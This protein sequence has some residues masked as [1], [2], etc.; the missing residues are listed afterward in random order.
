MLAE[1]VEPAMVEI[2]QQEGEVVKR[3]D[4][5]EALVEFD[6]VEQRRL[7]V[8]E[9]DIA[10]VQIAVAAAD[11]ALARAAVERRAKPRERHLACSR[12]G[13]DLGLVEERAGRTQIA[14]IAG[15]DLA[16]RH[17]IGPGVEGSASA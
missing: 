11:T 3:V 6:A 9:A 15:D 16:H 17:C 2:D 10:E 7:A 5:E 8:E 14:Q 4:A 1:I 13:F 12:E